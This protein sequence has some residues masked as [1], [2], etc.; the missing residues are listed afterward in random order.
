MILE[1]LQREEERFDKIAS[2]T[3]IDITRME[4]AEKIRML[5]MIDKSAV[6]LENLTPETV[7]VIKNITNECKNIT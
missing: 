6:D 2:Q 5:A 1:F 4:V 7:S 3:G